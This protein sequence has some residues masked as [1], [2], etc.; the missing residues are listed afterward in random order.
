MAKGQRSQRLS[1]PE[2]KAE[3]VELIRSRCA[4]VRY[5]GGALSAI[6]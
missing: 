2:F 4:A 1:S 6:G 3:T 5:R